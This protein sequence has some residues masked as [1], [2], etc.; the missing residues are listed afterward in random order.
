MWPEGSNAIAVI[1]P[2]S[3]RSRVSDLAEFVHKRANF[4]GIAPGLRCPE[5]VSSKSRRAYRRENA[6]TFSVRNDLKLELHR[7]AIGSRRL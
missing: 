1:E 2:I 3:A 7:P 6:R 4:A 5:I